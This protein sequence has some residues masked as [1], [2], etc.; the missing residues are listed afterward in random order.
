M[1]KIIPIL[2]VF[3]ACHSGGGEAPAPTPKPAGA[4][5]A[6]APAGAGAAAKPAGAPVTGAVASPPAVAGAPAAGAAPAAAPAP[7]APPKP[8]QKPEPA[9]YKGPWAKPEWVRIAGGNFHYGC[10]P[11]D[12]DCE[13]N[14]KPGEDVTVAPFE[15]MK[16]EVTTEQWAACIAAKKC[17]EPDWKEKDNPPQGGG[18]TWK[19]GGKEKHPMNCV[20]QAEAQNFCKWVGGRLPTAQEWEFA[21]KGGGSRIYPWGDEPYDEKKARFEAAD[22]TSPVGTHP[23]GA[24]KQGLQDMAGNVWEWTA[25]AAEGDMASVKGASWRNHGYLL[26]AS[27]RGR[28]PGKDRDDWIGFRCVK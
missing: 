10:E 7:G 28:R 25:D 23:A 14:E 9:T 3:A 6:A 5:A 12:T 13:P 16:T 17:E 22:G 8:G 2:F 24:T 19:V 21:A 11:Q 15:M 1:R 26:R 18:C 27:K 20:S 4:A